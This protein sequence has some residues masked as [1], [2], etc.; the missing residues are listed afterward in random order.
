M[1]LFKSLL[2]VLFFVC[3]QANALVAIPAFSQRVIDKT[4]TLSSQQITQLDSKLINFENAHAD[5]SQIAVLMIATLDGETIEQYA[6]RAFEQWKIG[7]KGI[8]NGVLLIIAK[9]DRQVRIEVGY[10]LEGELPD[11]KAKRIIEQSLIPAFRQNDFYQGI[12]HSLTSII[13]ILNHVEPTEKNGIA[14]LTSIQDVFDSEYASPLMNYAI[15]SFIICLVISLLLPFAG[16]KA[17]QGKRNLVTGLLNGLSTS[18]FSLFL[19]MPVKIV[20]PIL[21]LTFV[22]STLFSAMFTMR[23]QMGGNGR[24][25][26]GGFGGGFGGGSSRGGFG[27]GGGGRSGGGGASGRW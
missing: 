22:A 6:I 3:Y 11:I 14:Q 4:G 24:G 12:D 13:D 20:L 21:F 15:L 23:K 9:Q 18:G 26:R 1:R 27:G 19:G 2:I 5:G 10:G 25:P 8:D 16:L 7:K 17:S